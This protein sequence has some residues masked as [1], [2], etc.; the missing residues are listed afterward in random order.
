M[1]V[2]CVKCDATAEFQRRA[3]KPRGAFA[4]AEQ[5]GWRHERMIAGEVW[6]CPKHPNCKAVSDAR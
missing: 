3:E 5:A 1:L 4:Q 6:F 2:Q